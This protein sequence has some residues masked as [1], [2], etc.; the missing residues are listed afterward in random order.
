MPAAPPQSPEAVL[1]HLRTLARPE[2]AT[3]MAR[4]GMNPEG[5]LGISVPVLRA[6]ARSLGRQHALALA[7]WDSGV[8]EAQI[9]AALV[10]EPARFTVT[11]MN[12]WIKDM[13]AWDTCDQACTN[14]FAPSP[15]AWGRVPVW[16]LRQ[17]EFQRRAAFALLAALAVHD[18]QANDEAFVACLPLIEAA[19]D[20]ERNFVRKAVN[21]ALRQIGKRNDNLLGEAVL[22]AE[23]LRQRPSKAARWIAADAL[24]EWRAREPH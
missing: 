22:C 23:R 17:G 18:K 6:T 13:H 4:F 3:G 10:A 8:P 21:W 2:A 9:V 15:L 14:A 20:D 1:A 12:H 16:A 7:L 5:R 11:E 19:A 24:R